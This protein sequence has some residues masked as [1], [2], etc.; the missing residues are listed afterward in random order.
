M[1]RS[2]SNN[3]DPNGPFRGNKRD[4]WEGGTRVPFVVRWPGQAAPGLVV[5]DLVW[6]GDVFATIAAYLH[7][8]LPDDVAPDGESFL[9]LIRGQEKPVG[10]RPSLLVSAGRGDLGLKTIEGWKMVDSSG[11]G[12]GTSWDSK[13]RS[14]SN[15]AGTNRGNPKQLFDLR[16]DLGED[17]NLIASA[18]NPTEARALTIQLTGSDLLG[19]VDRYRSGTTADRFGRVS[20]NDRDGLP[21]LY[22]V[23]LSMDPDWP[24]DASEDP[25]GDG[26]DTGDE[27][28]AGTDPF[29]PE[30]VFR[31]LYFSRSESEISVSWSSVAARRYQ[32]FWSADLMTWE[33]D[34]IHSGTGDPV[35]ATIDVAEI[36]DPEQVFVRIEVVE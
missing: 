25:D 9:N 35:S 8:E 27:Y 28:S 1:S 31:I 30:D 7:E 21:N 33:P 12:N 2:L 22:E 4:V 29:D 32:V 5:D 18:G 15:A 3:R 34:S 36:S 20:D 23:S 16:V 19:E 24:L 13:N 11:G 14:I 26:E 6:Q 10:S 17:E